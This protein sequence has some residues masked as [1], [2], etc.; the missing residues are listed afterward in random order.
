[1]SVNTQASAVNCTNNKAERHV[2]KMLSSAASAHLNG[3]QKRFHYHSSAYLNSYDARRMAVRQAYEALRPN[4]RPAIGTLPALAATLDPWS[5]TNEPVRV[6]VR[7]KGNGD[8]RITAD[9]GITNRALQYLVSPLIKATADLHPHQYG[10]KGGTHAAIQYVQQ[11]LSEGH[12]YA[13]EHDLENCFGSFDGKKVPDLLC[14]PKEVT[15]SVILSRDLN[16]VSGNLYEVLS[17]VG[18]AD[19][20]D[21]EVPIL[22]VDVLAAAR[23]GFAQG[24]ASSGLVVEVLLSKVLKALPETGKVAGYSDNN[25][26]MAKSEKDGVMMSLAL[27]T[28]LKSHPAG[29]LRPTVRNFFGKPVDYLGHRLTKFT[30]HVQIDPTPDNEAKFNHVLSSGLFELKQPGQSQSQKTRKALVLQR[31]VRSWCAAFKLCTDMKA[32]RD[33]LLNQIASMA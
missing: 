16:L 9:F 8:Y 15:E 29:P 12:V 30:S 28:A 24:S 3:E 1:M 33:K 13:V 2:A 25:L 11:M 18:P 6:S 5:G 23:L 14:L 7:P 17:P 19:D 4:C 27:C 21:G 20:D 31:Y 22:I 32:C 26:T 10:C